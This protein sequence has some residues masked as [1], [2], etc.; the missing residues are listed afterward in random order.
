MSRETASSRVSTYAWCVVALLWPVAFLNYLD[1]QMLA[2]MKFSVMYDI[3]TIATDADWGF[4]PAVFKWVYAGLSP[5]GGYV[6][7]RFNRRRVIVASLAI[8]SAVTWATGH[9][10]T[11]NQMLVTRAL[12]GISE[13]CYIPAGLALISEFHPGFTRSRAIGIHQMAIYVGIM[14]GGFSGHVAEN[15]HLGWRFAF[16]A[17]GVVGI[18]YAIPLYFLLRNPPRSN[19]G[20]SESFRADAT[21]AGP[22]GLLGAQ[23]VS[24]EK[25]HRSIFAVVAELVTNGS[26]ILLIF[27]FML[28][29]LANWIVNDWMPSVLKQQFGIGQGVAGV[30]ATLYKNLAAV[31][32]AIVGGWLADRCMRRSERG[33][34]YVSALGTLMLAPALFGVGNA[35]SLAVAVAFLILFGFGW[36]FFDTNNMPILCQIVRPEHRATA[37]GLLNLVG[38]SCGGFADWGFGALRD[39]GV[40]LPV[41][42]GVFAGITVGSIV[43]VLLIRPRR[44]SA[45]P[46]SS[47]G[48]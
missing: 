27:Y 26:L 31:T 47:A 45:Q 5:L 25:P 42:F 29:G 20:G 6:A 14:V 48:G 4:L 15:P 28:P 16:S 34:I 35:G 13:A 11:H 33:R 38:I 46:A 3:P 24:T 37:Y 23:A 18:C 22:V 39:H 40:P 17:C 2:A 9:V 32:G 8:W 36:G 1:R 30:S 21:P 41:I 44:P 12:M 19:F 7:D 10:T 43:L